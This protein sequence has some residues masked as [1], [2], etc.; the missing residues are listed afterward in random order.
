M[1]KKTLL[2]F[3]FAAITAFSCSKYYDPLHSKAG[4]ISDFF[5]AVDNYD[6]IYALS[7]WN[8]NFEHTYLCINS[9][10]K[11]RSAF[12]QAISSPEYI[13]KCSFENGKLIPIEGKKY[14]GTFPCLNA[15]ED[16]V[17]SEKILLA[18]S[19]AGKPAAWTYFSN[20]WYD[21]IKFPSQEV[22]TIVACGKTPFIRMMPRSVFEEDQADPVYKMLDIVNG[23]YDNQLKLWA[24][25]AKNC[26]TNLLIEFGTEVNGSWFP[27]N[28]LYSGGGTTDGYGDP[29]YPDGP[30]IFRDAYRH[31]IDLFADEG[32]DNITWFFH[33]DVH[34]QPDQWWNQP[35][36][37]YPGDDYIDWIGVSIYGPTGPGEEYES[38]Y[39]LIEKAHEMMQ[40]V[41]GNKPYS[42]L[43]FGITE[44]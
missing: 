5:D 44:L 6:D 26:G 14:Y 8:E 30:E 16:T 2:L 40:N 11:S 38:P 10:E 1:N 22:E 31:I 9:S 21:N 41:S 28:G 13:S 39:D 36:Y 27:W 19:L 4:W 20:N 35:V 34:G 32:A 24:E 42:I 43:E 25:E 18:D 23:L 12:E 33:I 7:Y 29:N 17:L 15:E 3:L 37:Y